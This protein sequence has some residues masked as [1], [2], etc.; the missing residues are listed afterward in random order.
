MVEMENQGNQYWLL[1]WLDEYGART[2]TDVSRALKDDRAVQ[3][4]V[5]LARTYD[6]TAT[7]SPNSLL[8]G[9]GLDLSRHLSCLTPSCRLKRVD[10]IFARAWHYFDQILFCDDLGDAIRCDKL[11]AEELR[12]YISDDALVLLHIRD[13][14]AE[15]LVG[16]RS[17]PAEYLPT[18]FRVPVL[19][20]TFD[21]LVAE[22]AKEARIDVVGH[23]NE[24][25]TAW[26]DA[27]HPEIPVIERVAMHAPF[28]E[29][30]PEEDFRSGAATF[31]V[32]WHSAMLAADVAAAQTYGVPL[33][34]GV[35]YHARLIERMQRGVTTADAALE[36]K[37]PVLEGAPIRDLL[38]I[39]SEEAAYFER[40][41]IALRR[42]ITARIA[43]AHGASSVASEVIA[44]E[45]APALEAITARLK[46]SKR[47]LMRKASYSLSIG[48]L[49]TACGAITGLVPLIAGGALA[50]TGGALA[51]QAKFTD[52]RR[53]L[54]LSDMYFLW[55]AIAHVH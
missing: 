22:F 50:G 37:L 43:D 4:V 36:L 9:R 3:R 21:E 46:A 10:E 48:A 51:A 27:R 6:A 42:A 38:R 44:D 15:R 7:A 1:R 23:S 35:D 19:E 39:R 26:I 20:S 52:E 34:T 45:V 13:I 55:R 5:D 16:F 40:F 18:R 11:N 2:Q 14:G 17:K 32:Q 54:E 12:S 30:T 33:A 25:E 49:L 29:L 41:R 53:E 31:L 8:A 28:F 47:A 24:D